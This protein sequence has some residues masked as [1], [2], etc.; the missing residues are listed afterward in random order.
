[1]RIT[2]FNVVIISQWLDAS[3]NDRHIA[4]ARE[5]YAALQ[6]FLGATRYVN[7]LGN[8]EAGD[9]AAAAYGANYGRLRELKAK[10]DP[11]NFFRANV[12]IRPR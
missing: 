10:F 7:Y 5:T 12:N 6:P 8:D 2:G 1:M 4:W 9:P 3:E 11:D